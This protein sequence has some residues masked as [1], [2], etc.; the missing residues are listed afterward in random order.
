MAGGKVLV[1]GTAYDITK[2]KT[3]IGGTAYDITAGKTMVG[4]SGYDIKFE[5][6]PTLEDVMRDM[7]IYNAH[8]A[9]DNPADYL[10]G[11]A[12]TYEPT[13]GTYYCL[14]CCNGNMGIW[15]IVHT[16]NSKSAA[17]QTPINRSSTSESGLGEYTGTSIGTYHYYY[18]SGFKSGDPQYYATSTYAKGLIFVQFPHYTPEQVDAVLSAATMT[19]IVGRNSTSASTVR[20]TDKTRKFYLAVKAS[21]GNSSGFDLWYCNGS[22]YTKVTGTTK[23]A[24][25][26]SGSYLTLGS[27]YGCGITAIN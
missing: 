6:V 16:G 1:G 24:A 13:S 22:T 8:I 11:K 7:T 3:M 12:G 15:K 18:S 25:S 2:G 14:S 26:V 5:T 19:K 9:H 21:T 17:Q 23:A 20:T 4:G 27:T 10:S